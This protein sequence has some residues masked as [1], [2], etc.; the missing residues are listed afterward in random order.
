MSKEGSVLTDNSRLPRAVSWSYASCHFMDENSI[1]HSTCC[2]RRRPHLC[3]RCAKSGSIK[4][5]TPNPHFPP[6]RPVDVT[7]IN[8]LVYRTQSTLHRFWHHRL[9]SWQWCSPHILRVSKLRICFVRTLSNFHPFWLAERW[10]RGYNMRC[11]FIFH[12]A[13][14]SRHLTTVLNADVPNC[15]TTL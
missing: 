2:Q 4:R 8:E 3:R 11:A 7:A 5:S 9:V 13:Y 1:H 10:Q 6:Q 15:Y 14:N 12:L